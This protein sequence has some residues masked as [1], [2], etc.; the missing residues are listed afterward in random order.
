MRR[1]MEM[2]AAVIHNR[3]FIPSGTSA[4]MR[5]VYARAANAR[6]SRKRA[7]CDARDCSEIVNA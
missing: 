2:L 5:D 6:D 1:A 7:R 3:C 4:G